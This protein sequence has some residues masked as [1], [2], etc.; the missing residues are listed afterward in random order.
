MIAKEPKH[1]QGLI[2]TQIYIPVVPGDNS[3]LLHTL[4]SQEFILSEG[5]ISHVNLMPVL[6]SKT[7]FNRVGQGHGEENRTFIGRN[8]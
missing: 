8:S 4:Q 1:L 2:Q 7:Q 3:E 5:C 6:G